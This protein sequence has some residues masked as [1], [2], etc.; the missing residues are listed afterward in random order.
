MTGSISVLGHASAP[1]RRLILGAELLL[2]LVLYLAF[3]V[4]WRPESAPAPPPTRQSAAPDL[5]ARNAGLASPGACA[6][7]QRAGVAP[8]LA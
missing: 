1:R 2:L 8:S 3:G 4:I 5:A 6:Q 7:C